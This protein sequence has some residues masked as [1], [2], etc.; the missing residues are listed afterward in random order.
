MRSLQLAT[1]ENIRRLDRKFES[2]ASLVPDQHAQNTE[3]TAQISQ[4]SD[5]PQHC[6]YSQ[7]NMW[8]RMNFVIEHIASQPKEVRCALGSGQWLKSL[9]DNIVARYVGWLQFPSSGWY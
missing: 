5:Q 2:L 8:R 1:D 6:T 9:E 7:A 3:L 4:K